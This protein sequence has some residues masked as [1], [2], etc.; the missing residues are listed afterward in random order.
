MYPYLFGN[1]HIPMY[2]VCFVLGIVASTLLLLFYIRKRSPE[3]NKD[4]SLYAACFALVGGILGAKLLSVL[5]NINVIIEY[6]IG[7]VDVIKNGFVFYGGLIGGFIGYFIYGKVYKIPVMALTDQ[8][9]QALPLGHAIGRLGCFC[10]GCCYGKETTSAIGVIYEHPSDPLTP[11]GVKLIPTQLI[12]TCYCLLIFFVLLILNRKFKLKRGVSTSI[13]ILAYGT[14]RFINEFFRN[15]A[16]R[17]ELF[18]LSTSQWISILL[19]LSIGLYWIVK[20]IQSRK[21]IKL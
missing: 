11:V 21:R 4:D 20:L 19:M 2:G 14:C 7:I 8:G 17:G 10:A 9:S 18:N 16:E 13:Y 1:E 12:E 6:K 15:D 3:V 5:T